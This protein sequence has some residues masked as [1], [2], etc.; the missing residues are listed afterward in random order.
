M[1]TLRTLVSSLSH[2]DPGAND[3]SPEGRYRTSVTLT[4]QVGDGRRDCRAHRERR[5]HHRSR[6]GAEPRGELPLHADR[7]APEPAGGQGAR[8]RARAAR[9]PRVQRVDVR[10]ARRGRDAHRRALCGDRRD[11]RAERPAP[12]RRQHRRD[13]PAARD[14][15]GRD[16]S[17]GRRDHPREARPEGKDSRLRP[18]R[19]S[20]GGSA[21]HAPAE[22]VGRARARGRATAAGSRSRRRSSRS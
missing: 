15:P 17:E 13:E 18:S 3:M 12:R 16:R 10:G 21:R 11:R 6:S 5:R 4:A 7:E 2:F 19:V 1:D 8:R 22:D 20:H 9:R 14:R